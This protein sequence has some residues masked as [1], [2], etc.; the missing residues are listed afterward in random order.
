LATWFSDFTSA[1]ADTGHDVGDFPVPV[2]ATAAS[3]LLPAPV[4]S[5]ARH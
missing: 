4:V 5:V 1:L 3:S 2:P